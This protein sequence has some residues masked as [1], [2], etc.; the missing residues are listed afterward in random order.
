MTLTGR[1]NALVECRTPF[2]KAGRLS[3]RLDPYPVLQ[4]A[5]PV[6]S[7]AFPGRQTLPSGLNTFPERLDAFEASFPGRLSWKTEY[8]N[9]E[10]YSLEYRKPLRESKTSFREGRTPS[11]MAGRVYGKPGRHRG[12]VSQNNTSSR[13]VVASQSSICEHIS[14]YVCKSF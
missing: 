10:S 7:D 5:F 9:T 8:A 3:G 6:R 11:G 14:L 4:D 2:G 1:L 13:H 12:A